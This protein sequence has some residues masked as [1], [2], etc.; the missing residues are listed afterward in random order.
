MSGSQCSFLIF[1]ELSLIVPIH[2]RK[3]LGM[4]TSNDSLIPDLQMKKLRLREVQ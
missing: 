3:E 2:P 1:F 4:G